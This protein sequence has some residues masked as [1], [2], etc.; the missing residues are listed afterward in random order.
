MKQKM[1]LLLV[2]FLML[3]ACHQSPQYNRSS[4]NG[5]SG[6]IK[7]TGIWLSYSE[8]DEMLTDEAGVE[9][10]FLKVLKDC[11]SLGISVLY[12]Q[13]RPFCD[14]LY[15]SSLFPLREKAKR[16]DF[17]VFRF[18]VE[19]T[20]KAGMEIHAWVNPYRVS[21]MITDMDALP[22]ESPVYQ[23]Y[24]DG[25]PD[26]DDNAFI[27]NGIYLNPAKVEV[28]KLVLEGIREILTCYPVDGIHFD[29]YFYPGADTRLDQKTYAEY[30]RKASVP[31]DQFDWRRSHVD[32]LIESCHM[33]IEYLSP[34]CIFSVSPAASIDKNREELFADVK[35]W[36]DNR[37]IDRVIPQLYF[38]FE[39]PDES[40]RFET[41]LKEW[42]TLLQGN[43]C[44]ELQ[45]GLGCYKIETDTKADLPEWNTRDDIIAR[46]TEL[47]L[48][49][50][51]VSGVVFFSYR[52]L[53]SKK[54]R[55]TKQ[56]EKL[57]SYLSAY[58]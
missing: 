52:S 56:R 33:A 48:Q 10:Q 38:G 47:S 12:L 19:E 2:T 16:Y 43:D 3:T 23:W 42:K 24:H 4:Q 9:E 41:L 51:A 6:Q 29:D 25:D 31:K 7:G 1:A 36:I 14:T 18:M 8:I 54:D 5:E 20:H 34:S 49:D 28:R 13:V 40:Y 46:Q 50:C 35:K 55:N 27:C 26:N 30:C 37:W 32:A 11:K 53:F 57:A 45:I 58:S 39:Y 15:P 44:V 21:S 22:K 17:D